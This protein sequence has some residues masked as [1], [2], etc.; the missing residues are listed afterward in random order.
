MDVYRGGKSTLPRGFHTL[1]THAS[2]NGIS[3][4]SFQTLLREALTIGQDPVPRSGQGWLVSSDLG[5]TP[6]LPHAGFHLCG[7]APWEP[8]KHTQPVQEVH[9]LWE[10]GV[11]S[12]P[13]YPPQ[14]ES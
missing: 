5:A 14:P 8:P 6:S 3:Y 10:H 7:L 11:L 1:T 2:L 4:P 13:S 9:L 12:L